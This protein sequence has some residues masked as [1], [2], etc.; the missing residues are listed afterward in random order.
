MKSGNLNA[1]QNLKLQQTLQKLRFIARTRDIN[2]SLNPKK[3][4]MPLLGRF[5]SKLTR[6]EDDDWYEKLEELR[7]LL[8]ATRSRNQYESESDTSSDSE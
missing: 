3:T 5:N 7:S 6:M 1:A 2:Q 8:D 4:N